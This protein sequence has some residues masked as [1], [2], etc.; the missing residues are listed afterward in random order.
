MKNLY[1]L[2]FSIISFFANSQTV[3][4]SIL[5]KSISESYPE[6]DFSN[7]LLAIS[8]WSSSDV[9]SREVNKEYY[10]TWQAYQGA[11][12][13]GGLKGLIFISIS[14]DT[15]EINFKIASKKDLE[16][17]AFTICDYLSYD[18]KGVL[19]E[20]TLGKN[21]QNI[22]FDANGNLIFKNLD[23]KE[24]FNSFNNIMTR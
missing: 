24:V 5:R 21:I 23:S 18:S 9:I 22:V 13:K 4:Y 11:K 14:T 17:Y 3:D 15:K 10:R 12:L 16:N 20:M 1:I 7:K 8:V 2:I 6:I 19:A